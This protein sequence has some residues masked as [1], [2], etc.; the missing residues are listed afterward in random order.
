MKADSNKNQQSNSTCGW[1]SYNVRVT[2]Y[3]LDSDMILNKFSQML[4]VKSIM[5]LLVVQESVSSCN[6]KL[7]TF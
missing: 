1:K 7:R 3:F 5:F 6:M 4:V 2:Q